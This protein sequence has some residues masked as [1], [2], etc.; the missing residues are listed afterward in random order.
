[1]YKNNNHIKILVLCFI[2]ISVSSCKTY[3]LVERGDQITAASM[4]VEPRITWNRLSSS[5]SNESFW[6]IDGFHLNEIAFVAAKEGEYILPL[7]NRFGLISDDSPKYKKGMNL[8]EIPDLIQL[9]Y[10][11]HGFK[12][13]N[14]TKVEPS[15]F[16]NNKGFKLTFDASS[17]EGL[18]KAGM[19]YATIIDKKLYRNRK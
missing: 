14:I 7:R 3:Q 8:L 18:D 4:S 13:F 15:E 5:K 10:E 1:M 17:E 2:V 19:A 9:A 6:T 16:L 12:R 11:K